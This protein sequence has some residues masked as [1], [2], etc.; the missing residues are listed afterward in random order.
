MAFP[1]LEAQVGSITASATKAPYGRGEKTILDTNVRNVWQIPAERVHL[2]G[3]AWPDTLAKIVAL[4]A[5]ELGCEPEAV[6]AD[7]YKLLLYEKGGFFLSH[8]DSEKADGMFATLVI[9]LPSDHTGG[10]LIV[11]HAGRETRLTLEASD[12][13]VLPFAAFYADCEHEVRPVESGHRLCLIYNLIQQSALGKK[14]RPLTAPDYTS[15]ARAVAEVLQ[16]WKDDPASVPKLVYLLE[17]QYTPAALKFAALKNGDAALG[18][19][20]LAASRLAGCDCHLG[21]VHIS[22]TGTASVPYEGDY[23]GRR[24]WGR[25]RERTEHTDF[26]IMEGCDRYLSRTIDGW[27]APDDQPAKFGSLPLGDN[28]LLP[29]GALDGEPPDQ[30]RATEATGNEG[31]TY[32]RAYH[33]AAIVLWPPERFFDITIQTGLKAALAILQKQAKNLTEQSCPGLRARAAR[34]VEQW[35]ESPRSGYSYH[36]AEDAPL[37]EMLAILSALADPELIERFVREQVM[38]AFSSKEVSRLAEA[39]RLLPPAAAASLLGGTVD[40][41]FVASPSACIELLRRLARRPVARSAAHA[42]EPALTIATAAVRGLKQWAKT[43]PMR[44]YSDWRLSKEDVS[45]TASSLASL[46][47]SLRTIEAHQLLPEAASILTAHPESFPPDAMI[48]P[49]LVEVLESGSGEVAEAARVALSPLWLQAA[50]FL[51]ARSEHPPEEPRSWVRPAALHCP[52]RLCRELA[53]FA[54]SPTES[55]L[56]HKAGMHDRYHLEEAIRSNSLDMDV[57]TE[58]NTRPHVLVAT[59]NQASYLRR[60]QEYQADIGHMK[61]LLP[62]APPLGEPS[63]PLSQRLTAAIARRGD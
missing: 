2:R 29:A 47:R 1:L 42:Q 59:K 34:L 62:L 63:S 36:A 33:R 5:A 61:S 55:V 60:L 44:R 45:A 38:E 7:L 54:A 13:S 18:K 15:Q 46:L 30:Q 14:S 49:A 8:R 28:E 4:A 27:I 21:L 3:Q 10:D 58:T 22:E 6:R 53:R 41:R 26:E 35:G 37:A 17:H 32:E 31:A 20:L 56:R 51:L 25:R 12:P 52:C 19:T 16:R 48:V 24:S 50:E 23:Y 9:G 11:R 43:D 40:A 57:A 39:A